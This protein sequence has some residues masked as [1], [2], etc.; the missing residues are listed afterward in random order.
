[1]GASNSTHESVFRIM[2][3]TDAVYKLIKDLKRWEELYS[4]IEVRLH[5]QCLL[6]F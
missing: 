6:P 5:R 4:G 2:E 1:M 3:R